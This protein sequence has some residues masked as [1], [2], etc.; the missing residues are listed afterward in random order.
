MSLETFRAALEFDGNVCLGGGEPTLNKEFNTMLLEALANKAHHGDGHVSI[1]T[2]GSMTKTALLLARLSKAE[3]IDAQLSRDIYHDEID[4]R[5]VDA[6]ESFPPRGSFDHTPGIR[7]TTSDRDPRPHGR[8]VDN[9]ELDEDFQLTGDDCMCTDTFVRPNGD[10]TQCGCPDS[11][12][13]GNIKEGYD[14]PM[15]GECFRSH[16]FTGEALREEHGG[17]Y[18]HLLV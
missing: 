14:T 3:V 15:A 1:I 16:Y 12:I 4:Q 6:F 18:D 10:I 9:M 13:I 7:N 2:N 8:A 11:P 17:K 5:V